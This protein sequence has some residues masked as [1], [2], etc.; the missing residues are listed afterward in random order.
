[1]SAGEWIGTAGVSL[2]L[3]AF[4]FNLLGKLNS[5]SFLYLFLNII[6]AALA[7]WSSYIINFWPFVVLEGVW[8]LSSLFTLA[9]KRNK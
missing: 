6:G 2:L 8:A 1:M 9:T 5:Q 3:L 4:A 7:C